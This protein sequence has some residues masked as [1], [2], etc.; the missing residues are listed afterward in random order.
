MFSI[1]IFEIFLNIRDLPQLIP[2]SAATCSNHCIFLCFT[3][4]CTQLHQ[5]AL[6]TI[7]YWYDQCVNHV[8]WDLK[9]L[10]EMIN[11]S[12]GQKFLGLVLMT[13]IVDV[14]DFFSNLGHRKWCR[15]FKMLLLQSL[16]A[17]WGRNWFSPV[18]NFRLVQK[19]EFCFN[20]Y[21][22]CPLASNVYEDQI[23]Y[24]S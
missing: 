24:L 11:S 19:S 2:R 15:S 9:D 12:F 6:P 16:V 7:F 22:L 20:S 8:R 13:Y 17:V 1:E 18:P 4:F 21:F 14:G 3:V 23:C 5:S 10:K